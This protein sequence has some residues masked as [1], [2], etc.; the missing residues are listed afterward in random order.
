MPWN[1][2][3][4]LPIFFESADR[5]LYRDLLA[6]AAT[7]TISLAETVGSR[8]LF[9]QGPAGSQALLDRRAQGTVDLPPSVTEQTLQSYAQ[10]ARSAI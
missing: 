7:V 10:V 5:A 2:G 6:E 8:E 9:G 1:C 4:S 3:D